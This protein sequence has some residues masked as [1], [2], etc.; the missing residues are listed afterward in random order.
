[1]KLL[2]RG[3]P[4]GGGHDPDSDALQ[5]RA[6]PDACLWIGIDDET[7]GLCGV[8]HER[9]TLTRRRNPEIIPAGVSRP[10]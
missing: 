2:E 3:D 4:V 6:E 5:D 10:W 7:D 1:M 9:A 8:S